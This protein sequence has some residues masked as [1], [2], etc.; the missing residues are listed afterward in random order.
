MPAEFPYR[1]LDDASAAELRAQAA[2]VKQSLETATRAAVDI[3]TSI[4]CAMDRFPTVFDAWLYSEFGWNESIALS[5]LD[6]A[7]DFKGPSD[8]A[9]VVAALRMASELAARCIAARELTKARKM[10]DAYQMI[11]RAMGA[12]CPL[13]RTKRPRASLKSS[14][15]RGRVF[16]ASLRRDEPLP[17]EPCC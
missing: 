17:D 10:I 16:R 14:R 12:G 7:V 11:L 1:L 6:C 15:I 4:S 8:R 13:P 9:R 5:F 2:T 3:G